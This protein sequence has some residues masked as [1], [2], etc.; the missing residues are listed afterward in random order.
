MAEAAFLL[1]NIKEIMNVNMTKFKNQ[2]VKEVFDE[3]SNT[4]LRNSSGM[5]NPQQKENVSPLDGVMAKLKE[6]GPQ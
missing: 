2:G 3:R 5:P 4:K 1:K 6:K